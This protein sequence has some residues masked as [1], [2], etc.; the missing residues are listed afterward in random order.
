MRS[1]KSW[2]CQNYIIKNERRFETNKDTI[3]YEKENLAMLVCS[4]LLYGAETWTITKIMKTRIE[5]FELW[6]YR[7]VGYNGIEVEWAAL[8]NDSAVLLPHFR[9]LPPCLASLADYPLTNV[10]AL[11]FGGQGMVC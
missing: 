9:S 1:R 10:F 8:C 11:S 5:A 7:S 4:T 2:N 6:A 3:D